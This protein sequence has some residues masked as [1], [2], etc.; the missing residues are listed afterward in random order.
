[1]GTGKPACK[2]RTSELSIAMDGLADR[3][4]TALGL[5]PDAVRLQ[6]ATRCEI[7]RVKR[8]GCIERICAVANAYKHSGPLNRK[9]PITSESD[10]LATGAGYGIDAFGTGKSSGVEV[11]VKQKDGTIRKML[12]DVPFAVAG[13]LKFLADHNTP[14]PSPEI[15]V[16]GMTV[17]PVSPP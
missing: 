5:E 14:L 2:R 6:V 16:C 8:S 10:V 12:A 15:C 1:M 7:N 3:A 17:T 4:A 13:W 9:H 11:L